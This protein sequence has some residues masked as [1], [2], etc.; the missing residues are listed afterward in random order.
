MKEELTI[1]FTALMFYTRL[2]VPKWVDYSQDY[3]NRSTRYFPM[4]GWVV[5][6]LGALVYIIANHYLPKSISLLFSMVSTILLTGAFHEDGFADTCDGFGGGRTKQQTLDIMKDSRIGAYGAIGIF[7]MLLLKF[8]LLGELEAKIIPAALIASHSLSR[9][10]VLFFRRAHRYVRE[11]DD[12]KAKPMAQD[13]SKKDFGIGMIL[14]AMPL[15][16]LPSLNMIFCVVSFVMI[17]EFLFS[18][19]IVRRIGGYTGDCLGATQQLCELSC[20]MAIII[21]WKFI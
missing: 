14:G 16:L 11:N 18:K 21:S 7:L 15:I 10:A 5:G 20:Y 4:I 9:A 2:P 12:A 17:T 1:F 3:L 13:V 19:W 6:G 8:Q